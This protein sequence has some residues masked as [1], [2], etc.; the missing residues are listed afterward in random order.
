[1]PAYELLRSEMALRRAAFIKQR[2][3]RRATEALAWVFDDVGDSV[4]SFQ[5]VCD[6]LAVDGE[7]LRVRVRERVKR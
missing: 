5:N 7:V 4:F 1:M 2:A 6:V 3:R